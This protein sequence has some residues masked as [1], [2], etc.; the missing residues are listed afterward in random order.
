LSRL[1]RARISVSEHD[2]A[3]STAIHDAI[4]AWQDGAELQVHAEDDGELLYDVTF[5]LSGGWLMSAAAKS[6]AYRIGQA[7]GAPCRVGWSAWWV[8]DGGTMRFEWSTEEDEPTRLSPSPFEATATALLIDLSIEPADQRK[9]ELADALIRQWL[10][11]ADAYGHGV[12]ELARGE[13]VADRIRSW[14]Q[15]L[16]AKV[17]AHELTVAAWDM[18]HP[19]EVRLFTPEVFPQRDVKA[20]LQPADPM[21]GWLPRNGRC[22]FCRDGM[23]L[24]LVGYRTVAPDRGLGE[25][26][27]QAAEGRETIAVC[28]TCQVTISE[29]LEHLPEAQIGLYETD[30]NP[31]GGLGINPSLPCMTCQRTIGDLVVVINDSLNLTACRR[32]LVDAQPLD[33]QSFPKV[34][35]ATYE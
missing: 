30:G 20:L 23:P 2:G 11:G 7:N 27:I 3:R 5:S 1:H 34:T 31:H 16:S 13:H 32:C 10:P 22:M 33:W 25:V 12:V 19:H 17:G 35:V 28:E 15:E 29:R 9:R 18:D 21:L 24:K 8:E 26:D 6:H 14:R 4:A